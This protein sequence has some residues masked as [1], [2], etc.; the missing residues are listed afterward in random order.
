MDFLFVLVV[1]LFAGTLAGIVGFGSSIILMP[2][3]V[4]A[5]GP[6]QAVPIMAIAAI[7]ANL[8]R[9]LAWWRE[10]D[11]RVCF[12]YAATATPFAA[13]GAGTLLVVPARVVEVALGVF[14]IVMIFIRR[15]MAAHRLKLGLGALAAIGVPVGFLTGLVASTGPVTVPIFLAAGLVKGAF[16]SSEAA[17]SLVVYAAKAAV[18]RT[19]GALPLEIVLKGLITGSTLMA[20]AFL[21]KRFV[22]AMDAAR[23]GL[24]MDG[25]MLLSGVTLLVTAFI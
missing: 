20:G 14:F 2:V 1:G 15:W 9:I 23:F 10:V 4:I 7:M 19:F 25:L 16:L 12:A 13:L 22:L 6:I 5:F 3:L 11:W 17:A 8:S 24:L 18:F 21:A